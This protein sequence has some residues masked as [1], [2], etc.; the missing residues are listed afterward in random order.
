MASANPAAAVTTSAASGW[1][2]LRHPA[3]LPDARPVLSEQDAGHAPYD[4]RGLPRNIE[5]SRNA[6]AAGPYAGCL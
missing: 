4:D 6:H 1:N 5:A 2:D 3:D